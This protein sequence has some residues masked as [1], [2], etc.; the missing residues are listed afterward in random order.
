MELLKPLVLLA[1]VALMLQA[2]LQVNRARL[3]QTLQDRS[4]L[5]RALLA[6]FVLVPA[7]AF[8]LV[9]AMHLNAFIAA[10]ILLM[11]IAPGVPFL[12]NAAGRKAGGSLGFALALCFIMPALSIVTAPLTARL[13]LP[14]ETHIPVSSVI[15]TLAIF[16]LAPLLIGML[17]AD[18]APQLAAKLVRPLAVVVTIAILAVLVLLAPSIAKAVATVYGSYGTAAALV[19]VLFSLA[20]GWLLGGPQRPYRNTLGVATALRN[21]GLALTVATVDFPGTPVAAMVTAYLLVQVIVTVLFRVFV[22][23]MKT[24]GAPAAAPV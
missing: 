3:K 16:Q 14:A 23:L 12:P 11:A 8:L 5:M 4:L 2:G 10:G 18:R 13:V 6:N 19:I 21:V 7:F 20:A 24:P 9:R 1:F 17:T 15:V 22:R